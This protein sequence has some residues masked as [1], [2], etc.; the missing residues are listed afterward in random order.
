MAWR[1]L[2]YAI[3]TL[4]VI[5]LGLS[6]RTYQE[7]LPGVFSAHF[8]DVLWAL[9]VFLGLSAIAPGVQPQWRAAITMAVA[10]VVEFSQLLHPPWLDAVRRTTIGRLALGVG[11]VWS[12]LLCYAAGI[13]LGWTLELV[14]EALTSRQ[15]SR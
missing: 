9:M 5:V 4:C 12:D 1:R 7:Q 2:T 3:A 8:G 13:A 14:L 11:F 10:C 15:D 6:S